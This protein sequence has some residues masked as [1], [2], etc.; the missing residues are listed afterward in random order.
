MK[1]G[2]FT[3][4]YLPVIHGITISIDAF[5]KNLEK[6]GHEVYIYTTSSPG[7]EDKTPKVYRFKSIKAIKNP[8]MRFGFPVVQNDSLKEVINSKLDIVHAHTPLSIGL[9]GKF[10]SQRQKIPLI[11][12]H[13]TD[14]PEYAK[15]Y[16]LKEKFITPYLAK[17]Y[18]SWFANLANEVIAP[19]P[20][21]EAQ[22]KAAGVKRRIHILPTGI[23]I[24]SFK[25]T[26]ENRRAAAELRRQLNILPDEKVLIFVG[27]MGKEKNIEFLL[28]VFKEINKT[29]NDVKFLLIGDGPYFGK[30]KLKAKK[31][32]L[33]TAHFIGHIPHEKIPTYYQAANLF[34]FAS[35]TD[36]QGIVALEAMASG[37]PTVALQDDALKGIIND[38]EN[39]FF[40]KSGPPEVFA[41]KIIDI[42]NDDTL[43]KK[44]SRQAELTV[45]NFSQENQTEKL[46]NIYNSALSLYHKPN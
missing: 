13:H 15:A 46:L 17:L 20:K 7:Y 14:Y 6:K 28:H 10:I 18:C 37:L 23:N 16:L 5:R 9:I 39:G 4:S 26:E 27:R 8:E 21:I 31:L 45:K 38:N 30:L 11:Y 36:T 41:R 25:K 24:E 2:F 35:L 32:S 3:D 1:I 43:Y 33:D 29:R 44:L 19:S 40:I 12:T 34:V 22:L 42:F